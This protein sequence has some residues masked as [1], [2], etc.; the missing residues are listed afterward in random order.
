MYIEILKFLVWWLTGFLLV[1]ADVHEYRL[2]K[3]LMRDYDASS[4]E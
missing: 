4:R 1:G 3:D 2:L